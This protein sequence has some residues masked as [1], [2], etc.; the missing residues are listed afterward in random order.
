MQWYKR[1]NKNIK[2]KIYL[3]WSNKNIKNITLID[4]TKSHIKKTIMHLGQELQL[5]KIKINQVNSHPNLIQSQL[6]AVGV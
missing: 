5:N 1:A 4:V 3:L 6:L 2:L